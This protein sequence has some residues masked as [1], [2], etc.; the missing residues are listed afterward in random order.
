[1]K[2]LKNRPIGVFDSGIGGLTVLR[3]L[4]R[5]LPKETF[6]YVGDTARVP[7]G[8][9]SPQTIRRYASE[10]AG[11][12]L[13]KRVKAL[14]VA[15]NSASAAALGS[16]K[17]SPVPVIGVIEPGARAAVAATKRRK[18]GVIGTKATISSGAYH[19]AIKRIQPR[20]RIWGKACPLFVPLVEEGRLNDPITRR[21]I[22]DYLKP[23]KKGGV[24]ALV[25]G[26][27]HY[28]LLKRAIWSVLGRR[29]RLI[30]SAEETA[31]AVRTMLI[32]KGALI[33]QSSR[34]N[35]RFYTTDDPLQFR[36]LGRLF[37][38]RPL[39]SVRFLPLENL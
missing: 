28:P 27:T 10:I 14:V 17:K 35:H 7:Y 4:M 38:G 30:D 19:R 3:E 13:R 11:F 31:R 15:C 16:L 32:R 21:V 5:A 24:D 34:K 33:S 23:L 9:K 22:N 8:T 2:S 29:I 36:Q 26:C 1:M 37:L 6:F 18:I 20:I 25:L 12:L 39:R